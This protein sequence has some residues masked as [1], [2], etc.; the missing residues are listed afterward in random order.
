ML[1]LPEEVVAR[2]CMQD[3][4]AAFKLYQIFYPQT[5]LAYYN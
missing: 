2:K 3:A 5:D 4:M 1:D